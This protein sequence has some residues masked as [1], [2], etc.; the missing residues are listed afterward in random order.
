MNV[1]IFTQSI[2]L[3]IHVTSDEKVQF[4]QGYL[5]TEFFHKLLADVFVSPFPCAFCRRKC[6]CS[7]AYGMV[8]HDHVTCL[9]GNSTKKLLMICCS[10]SRTTQHFEWD[11]FNT[12][13]S[14]VE[15]TVAFDHPPSWF[16]IEPSKL[17]IC[18]C[19][20]IKVW[21]FRSSSTILVCKG[22]L[23]SS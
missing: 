6:R 4:F 5:V 20:V 3:S 10:F 12:S 22:N 13:N 19:C 23:E 9:R 8:S 15:P 14:L 1:F 16:L 21:M 17:Q 18:K 7:L 2:D 11:S